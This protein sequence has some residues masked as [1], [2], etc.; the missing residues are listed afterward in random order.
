MAVAETTEAGLE[1]AAVRAAN[2]ASHLSEEPSQ[3]SGMP[4][5]E[6]LGV[7]TT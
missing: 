3:L 2:A 4:I 1:P 5:S 7:P 6:H